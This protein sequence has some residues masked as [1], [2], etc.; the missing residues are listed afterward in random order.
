[1]EKSIVS[2]GKFR[3]SKIAH[4]VGIA[5]KSRGAREEGS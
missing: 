3:E 2:R 1:M 4:G 5:G